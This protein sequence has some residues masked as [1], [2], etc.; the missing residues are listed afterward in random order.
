MFL[1]ASAV[2]SNGTV[3]SRVGAA[4]VAML[5]ASRELPVGRSL[6]SDNQCFVSRT[7]EPSSEPLSLAAVLPKL[8]LKV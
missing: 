7:L 8:P 3:I 2:L 1:G 6:C 5:A 4:A